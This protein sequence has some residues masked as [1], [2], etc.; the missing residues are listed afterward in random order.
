MKLLTPLLAL[1]LMLPGQARGEI[2]MTLP[3]SYLPELDEAVAVGPTHPLWLYISGIINGASSTF[4][5]FNK[6]AFFCDMHAFEDVS[7]TRDLIVSYVERNDLA[8]KP[9]ATL[10]IV[11]P[12]AYAEA[13][14]CGRTI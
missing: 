9:Y 7:V 8:D 13:Y 11:V 5:V 12:L 6:T 2:F 3:G 4:A 10:E 14:P 1:L